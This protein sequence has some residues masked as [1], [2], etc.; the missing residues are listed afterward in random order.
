MGDYQVSPD[1]ACSVGVSGVYCHLS[2]ANPVDHA[3]ASH[4]FGDVSCFYVGRWIHRGL[5]EHLVSR[6]DAVNGTAV[7][8]MVLLLT[9]DVSNLRSAVVASSYFANESSRNYD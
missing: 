9:G 5:I 3:V 2:G 8:G 6:C 7:D 1:D 4:D